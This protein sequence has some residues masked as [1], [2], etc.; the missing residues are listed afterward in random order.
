LLFVCSEIFLNEIILA[1]V[2]T[3][4]P[5]P[6]HFYALEGGFQYHLYNQHMSDHLLRLKVCKLSTW[7]QDNTKPHHLGE[8]LWL[9]AGR[10]RRASQQNFCEILLEKYDSLGMRL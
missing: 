5:Q 10:L 4:S 3:L 2:G 6:G 1:V 8:V 7:P 9:V